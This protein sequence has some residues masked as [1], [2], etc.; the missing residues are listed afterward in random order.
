[1][2]FAQADKDYF[3]AVRAEDPVI[4]EMFKDMRALMEKFPGTKIQHLVVRES[5]YGYPQPEGDR[6]IP[7][8]RAETILNEAK[9]YQKA[10]T[11]TTA[12]ER[13][14]LYTRYKQ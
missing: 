7:L 8:P 14:R 13:R 4:D 12:K 6:Y 5:E 3:A 11:A 2:K 1:M 9:Q 10:K